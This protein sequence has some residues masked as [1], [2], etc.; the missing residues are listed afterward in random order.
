MFNVTE[1][2]KAAHPDAHAGILVMQSVDN[3]G[4][5]PELERLKHKLEGRLRA[6][7]AGK[8]RKFLETFSTIPAYAAYYRQFKKTY[9]VQ[10]QLESIVFK[11]KSIPNAAAL[12]EAMFL[13]E[14]KNLLLTAGHDFNRLDLPVTLSVAGGSERYTLLR[15]PEQVLKANDMFMSD[16]SGVVSSIVYGPDRRTQIRAET[17]NVLF[18]VYAPAGIPPTAVQAH[19]QEIRDYVRVVSPGAAVHTLQVFGATRNPD[20][21][22]LRA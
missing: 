22:L 1:N 5:H 11:G 4:T 3:P 16:R 12:V 21:P 18:A 9:H 19:L 17:R 20:L 13:A 8:D 15:G 2:W 10:G 6:Q 7:F 14:V